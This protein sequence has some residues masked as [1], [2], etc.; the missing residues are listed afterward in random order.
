[1]DAGA[2]LE[3]LGVAVHASRRANI[4]PGST[5]LVLGAGT[6]GL[7]VAAVAKIKGAGTVII[8]DIDS[9]RVQ[10]AVENKFAHLGFTVPRRRAEKIE[11]QLAIAK[12]I[13][14]EVGKVVNSDNIVVGEVDAVFECTGVPSC[15]QTAIYVNSPPNTIIPSS[16]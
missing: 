4:A 2:L 6:V 5:V 8:A 12:E 1:M 7:L 3:P 15:L 10:F 16:R 11:D 13:A 9:G 14:A